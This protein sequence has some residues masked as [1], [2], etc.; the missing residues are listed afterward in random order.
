MERVRLKTHTKTHNG[1]KLAVY[2]SQQNDD[3]GVHTHF[4][5]IYFGAGG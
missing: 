5:T 4:N 1:I 2:A 3:N